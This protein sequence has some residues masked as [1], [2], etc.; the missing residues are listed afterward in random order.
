MARLSLPDFPAFLE[1]WRS[2]TADRA[3]RQVCTAVSGH[4]V[5]EWQA[6]LDTHVVD[7]VAGERI[8]DITKAAAT[9]SS[10]VRLHLSWEIDTIIGGAVTIG[11][12]ELST[13]AQTLAG[14]FATQFGVLSTLAGSAPTVTVRPFLS[15]ND[16]P[17]PDLSGVKEQV[18]VLAATLS[19]ANT[20]RTGGGAA[21]GALLGTMVLP[22]VGT[23]L[24]GVL[25]G[26]VASRGADA[27]R[28]QFLAKV[29]SIIEAARMEVYGGIDTAVDQVVA[30]L[31]TR[32]TAITHEY[33]RRWGTEIDRLTK[34]EAA[35]RTRLGSQL[36]TAT[37]IAA[38]ARSR[39]HQVAQ[40][41]HG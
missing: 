31:G 11:G 40:L 24:G 36:N 5:D 38:Q 20:W 27:T 21:A 23:L 28:I 34:A 8:K 32:L 39:I 2:A 22:G 33:Q 37:A 25:G 12:R 41:R 6:N 16:L 18:S 7:A 10:A 29:R 35:Q 19:S 14:E 30:S 15:I 26:A 13:A 3:I 4:A 9:V 17:T 1:N